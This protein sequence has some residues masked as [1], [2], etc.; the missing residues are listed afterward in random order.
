MKKVWRNCKIATRIRTEEGTPT[1]SSNFKG[2]VKTSENG[3]EN[4][5]YK[6]RER[7]ERGAGCRA[8]RVLHFKRDVSNFKERALV[9]GVLILH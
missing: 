1:P 6:S 2:E 5:S 7:E 8:A 3:H 4:G 9:W